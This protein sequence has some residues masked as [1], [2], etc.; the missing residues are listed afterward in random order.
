[1]AR[2]RNEPTIAGM[3][4]AR[5][6]SRQHIPVEAAM[7]VVVTVAVALIERYAFHVP[8]VLSIIIIGVRRSGPLRGAGRARRE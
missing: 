4:K 2:R 6:Q 7:L 8:L 3:E 5:R 1:V